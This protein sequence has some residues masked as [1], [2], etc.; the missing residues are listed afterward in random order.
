MVEVKYDGDGTFYIHE[1]IYKSEIELIDYAKTQLGENWQTELSNSQN[2]VISYYLEK[3]NVNRDS[4]IICDNNKP[5]KIREL[6]QASFHAIP[7]FKGK[8]S[9]DSGISFIQRMNIIY[10]KESKN[11]GKE[12]ELYEW[13]VIKGMNLER[14]IKKNDH[15]LDAMRYILMYLKDTL[16]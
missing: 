4:I 11:L 13:E 2:S 9:V 6:R 8:D 1:K 15:A 3:L 7:T 10:T 12:Y 16:T 14:P 5:E